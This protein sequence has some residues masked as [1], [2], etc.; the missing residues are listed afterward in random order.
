MLEL[1]A[2]LRI[3]MNVQEERALP[4]E[5]RAPVRKTVKRRRV[6]SVM[7]DLIYMAARLTRH[8]GRWG[9]SLWRQNPWR[10]I[11]RRLYARFAPTAIRTG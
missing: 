8:A 9:L 4:E 3:M 1:F 2:L 11:W 7:Q 10:H 6:K 5:E